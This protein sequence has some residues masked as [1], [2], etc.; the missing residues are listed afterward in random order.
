[1]GG[2]TSYNWTVPAG[3]T[4]VGGQGTT[5][6]NV[7]VGSSG[8]QVCVSASN[9][10]GSSSPS[11]INVN[12]SNAPG[13]PGPISG[14]ASL[15]NGDAGIYSINQVGGA[16]SYNWTVP[17]GWTIVSGQG[18]TF[19]SVVAGSSGGQVCV[20]ASN[21]CGSSSPSCINV[22]VSNVP[23][24]PGPISGPA[25][26]CGGSTVSYSIAPVAGATSYNW[27]VPSGWSIVSG[28][29]TTSINVIV[30]SSGGQ[31]C[32]SASN[33]CGSSSP[34][35]VSVIVESVP[36]AG[37]SYQIDTAN[38]VV[39]F[40]DMSVGGTSWNWSFGDGTSSSV[41]NPI[42]TYSVPDTYLVVLIVSNMCGS[43]TA[44]TLLVI[45][46]TITGIELEISPYFICNH[47]GGG[48]LDI[49]AQVSGKLFI[50]DGMGQLIWLGE[51][52]GG[53]RKTVNVEYN[54]G[55]LLVEF[56]SGKGIETRKVVMR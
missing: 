42:H 33:S 45:P 40:Y 44:E 32:V 9:S 56:V 18:T 53:E 35:C 54:G 43:D 20:S 8:G 39:S 12:V 46:G 17:A 51:L 6:I 41:Q 7:V 28:Q 10:C 2:A 24:S 11:C 15:C 52:R 50:Y 29:G 16:T 25:S 14:P 47:A 27:T 34:S 13:S 36:I 30:G 19:I 23:G 5:S 48:V 21:S 55:F 26:V 38:L 3:W 31:V 22:N 1:V 4:I 37:L 49:Y